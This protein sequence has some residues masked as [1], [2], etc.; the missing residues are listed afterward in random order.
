MNRARDRLHINSH[1]TD[2][3]N[4]KHFSDNTVFRFKKKPLQVFFFFPNKEFV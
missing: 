2:M 3:N 4:A 1:Y